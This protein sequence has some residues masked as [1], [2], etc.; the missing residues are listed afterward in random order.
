MGN[1]GYQ[2]HGGV[3][4]T[5]ARYEDIGLLA[6]HSED[7]AGDLAA[8]SAQGHSM[9]VDPG[10]LASAVLNPDG[11]AKI[12]AGLLQALDGLTALSLSFGERAIAL[13]TVVASYQAVDEAQARTIDTLRWTAGYGLGGALQAGVLAPGLALPLVAPVGIAGALV[14][15][16]VDW[17]QL[18]TE[19]PGILDN[20]VGLGPGLISSLPGTP[21]VSD[22]PGA[23]DLIGQLY[24]DGT[25][26]RRTSV[27][28]QV[29]T[30]ERG[31]FR[32]RRLGRRWR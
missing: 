27:R 2:M 10:L 26:C 4:G 1:P 30:A 11:F 5:D 8:V 29:G 32:R 20:L 28:P 7:L 16:E 18:L 12:E 3:G 14:G 17:E 19:H 24:E 21:M 6:Q 31:Q 9:L 23:A 15:D 25:H 22:V 13:H